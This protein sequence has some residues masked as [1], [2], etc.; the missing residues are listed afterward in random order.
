MSN[1]PT[2]PTIRRRPQATEAPSETPTAA[3]EIDAPAIAPVPAPKATASTPRPVIGDA[4]GELPST[5]DFAALFGDS[6]FEVA[7]VQTG[8]RIEATV[9]AIDDESV[10]VSLGAKSEGV[11]DRKDLQDKDG[12]LTVNI[13][14]TVKVYVVSTRGG[15]IRL[16]TALRSGDG[17]FDMFFEAQAQQIPV[18]GKVVGQNK[19]G[20]DVEIAGKRAFCPTSQISAHPVEDPAVFVGQTLTFLVTRCDDGGRNVVVSARAHIERERAAQAAQTREKLVVGATLTGVVSRV[21]DFGAFIDLGGI[22]GLAHVSELAWTR[23]DHPSEVVREGQAVTVKVLSIEEGGPKGEPR[24][25]LS[26]KELQEDPF[27]DAVRAIQIGD[28]LSSKVTRLA[29]F[30][31]FVEVAPGIEG[32]VHISELTTGRR[33]KHPSEIVSVGDLVEVQVLAIDPRKRQIGLSMRRLMDDPWEKA[34]V[35]LPPGTTVQGTIDGVESFGA[36]VLFENGLRG[37]LPWSQ[38]A[39]GEDRAQRKLAT[40]GETIEVK[41]LEIDASRGRMTLTRRNE[42]EA[43]EE[44]TNVR[45]VLAKQNRQED[46]FGTFGDLLAKFRK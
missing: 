46:G 5:D 6:D 37:L 39:E 44:Q 26:M 38:L 19:G 25:S 9:V 4:G 7:D 45:A 32:L 12:E 13:G 2:R 24:I 41:V 40:P 22:D 35:E 23:P 8:D 3:V 28:N 11:I 34:A 33:V 30:G 31:A 27:V 16:S 42:I 29:D 43:R 36:F 18:E 21:A 1:D 14:E 17:G 15:N 10:F 20:F